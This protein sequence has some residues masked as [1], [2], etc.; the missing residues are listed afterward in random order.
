ME[1]S[2]SQRPF[3][4][5]GVDGGG[6]KTAAVVVDHN[7]QVMGRGLAGS[8]NHH[9]VGL[10]QARENLLAA[11]VAAT[12]EAGVELRQ[13]AA[14]AWALAG[15]DRP[16][17]RR[18]FADLGATLLPGIPLQVE[19]DAL[20]ALMGGLGSRRGMVLIAGTGMI[21]YGENEAGAAARAGR[22]RVGAFPR[23]R[24]RL[25]PHPRSATC[26]LSGRR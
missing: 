17:E 26:H 10:E 8:S 25:R 6:S 16:A 13:A 1:T 19:N 3:F 5:I 15:V 20:A 11:M 2:D 7:V 22:G 23:P 21:A 12:G 9:N 4:V 18:L 14:V 24:Q